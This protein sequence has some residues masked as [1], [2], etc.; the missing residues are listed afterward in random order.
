ME[1]VLR[2]GWIVGGKR[3]LEGGRGFDWKGWAGL[4]S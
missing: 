3:W 2:G 4:V 1:R